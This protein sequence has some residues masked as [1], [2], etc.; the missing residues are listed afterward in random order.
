MA[1]GLRRWLRTLPD[2][3][4]ERGALAGA[5][6]FGGRYA[7]PLFILGL[8][9][10]GTTLVYQ[11][12]VHRLHVAYFTNGVGSHP[13]APC[14]TTAG[15]L[16][17]NPPYRSDFESS[18]GRSSGE[19]APREAGSFWL[20]FFD[21]DAYETRADIADAAASELERSVRC[22]QSLFDGAP[23]VNK[24]VKHLLHIDA[25]AAIFSDAHFLLVDRDRE[26]VAVSVLRGRVKTLGGAG[27][28]F[29]AKPENYDE[30][31]KLDPVAQ[32]VAQL[33][34]LEQRMLADLSRLDAKRV[35]R[36][37]YES[38][39][40]EPE[41]VIHACAPVFD[42]VP[43][44]NPAHPRFEIRRR[45]PEDEMEARLVAAVRRGSGA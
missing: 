28:W 33:D 25:L 10:S 39:C 38:F 41:S 3:R 45:P 2:R 16:R 21:V 24:N 5:S 34:A 4:A 15:A 44:K 27:E 35:H 43:E 37:V 13:F 36:I 18:Y 31:A 26:D 22:V 12:I 32:I 20:R 17:A 7:P 8:P 42:G 23:F 29:S 19:M 40:A 1:A 9:R 14:A 30:L 6:R 11:Y